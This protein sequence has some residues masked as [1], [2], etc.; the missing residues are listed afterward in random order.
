MMDKYHDV[1]KWISEKVA[2][3]NA[4]NTYPA[5]CPTCNG[6]KVIDGGTCEDCRG[7]GEIEYEYSPPSGDYWMT[8]DTYIG[9]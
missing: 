8:G 9:I 4:G 3:E 6:D 5:T 2:R 1:D 7:T